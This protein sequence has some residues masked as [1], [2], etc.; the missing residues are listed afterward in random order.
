VI[1]GHDLSHPEAVVESVEKVRETFPHLPQPPP[2]LLPVLF[3]IA[4]NNLSVA[5]L[6]EGAVAPFCNTNPLQYLI[7]VSVLIVLYFF[8]AKRGTF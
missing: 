7:K 3:S 2:L 6:Q 8:E 4:K 5:H 1:H